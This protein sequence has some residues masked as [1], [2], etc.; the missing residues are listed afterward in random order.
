MI[1]EGRLG[2]IASVS[3]TFS[4]PSPTKEGD[5]CSAWRYKAEH[6]GGGL[7]MDVGCHTLDILD[8]LLGPISETVAHATNLESAYNVEDIVAMSF[9]ISVPNQAR[10][11]L[12]SATWCFSGFE[13]NDEIV[14]QGSEGVLR[15]STFGKEPVRLHSKEGVTE[16]VFEAPKHVQQPL[17]QYVVNDLRGTGPK[18]PS[19]GANALRVARVLD[20]C[21]TGYYSGRADQFWQWPR[22]WAGKPSVAE[23]TKLIVSRA[24]ALVQQLYQS[25][26]VDDSHG[27]KHVLQVLHNLDMALL[28]APNPASI[29]ESRRLACRLA[30]LLHDADDS[31]YFPATAATYANA[32]DIATHAGASPDVVQDMKRMIS[33]VSCSHNGNSVPPEARDSPE[34][35]WPRWADRLEAVGK[36]GV[37][38]CYMYNKHKV[39]LSYA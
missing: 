21:L 39:H 17:I 22:R 24:T 19:A 1:K 8:F 36:I 3:Y 11:A 12:G 32:V 7:I 10:R 16:K 35:L 20:D 15:L 37:A 28:H 31:K 6:S 27:T 23:D 33:Y 4:R 18:A 38:R 25:A 29:S 13:N 2:T 30:A 34:L 5:D 26:G 9:K 14:I